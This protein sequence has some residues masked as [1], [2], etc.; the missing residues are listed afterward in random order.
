MK[1][2]KKAKLGLY[3]LGSL[4]LLFVL[5]HTAPV[6]RTVGWGLVRVASYVTS[7]PVS[8]ERL[9]YRL[10]RGEF[11][12]SGVSLGSASQPSPFVLNADRIHLRI[13]PTLR[14][15][16]EVKGLD[17]VLV[18]FFGRPRRENEGSPLPGYLRRLRITDGAVRFKDHN[19]AGDLDEWLV[20]EGI[21]ADALEVEDGHRILFHAERAHGLVG[22]TQVTVDALDADLVLGPGNSRVAS[23]TIFKDDSYVRAEG[24]LDFP[25]GTT[26]VL[27]IRYALDG[28]LAR[29][30]DDELAITGVATGRAQARFDAGSVTIDI[31]LRSEAIGWKGVTV[32]DVEAA[33]TYSGGAVRIERVQARG[34]GGEAEL[35]GELELREAGEQHLEL[36]WSGLDVV[37]AARH[38]G[39]ETLPF[40]ARISGDAQLEWTGWQLDEA[41]GDARIRLEPGADLSGN[42]RAELLQ[43]SLRLVTDGVEFVPWST[44][45]SARTTIGI[46][47]GGIEAEYELRVSDVAKLARDLPIAISGA[48]TATGFVDGTLETPHWTAHLESDALALQGE[49]FTLTADLEGSTDT[50]L[51]HEARL[52]GA[53]G[54]LLAGG[55]VPLDADQSWG[56]TASL[57]GF[58]V[59]ITDLL[60]EATIDGTIELTGRA[61][62]PDWTTQLRL[63]SFS[64]GGREGSA[65]LAADKRD[66]EIRIRELDVTYAGGTLDGRGLYALDSGS[67]DG[68]LRLTGMQLREL[69]LFDKFPYDVEGVVQFEATFAG[70]LQKPE[71]RARLAIGELT[72]N[73]TALPAVAFDLVAEDGNV[74]IEGTREGGE[75]LLSGRLQ[76]AGDYPLHL[77]IPL[78]ALPVTEWMHSIGVLLDRDRA[79]WLMEGAAEV[80]VNLAAP[81]TLAYEAKV[82]SMEARFPNATVRASP[83]EVSGNADRL[84]ISGFEM[85]G[86]RLRLAVNGTI[87]FTRHQAID[88]VAKGNLDLA[89]LGILDPELTTVGQ[90]DFNVTIGGSVSEPRVR[91]ELHVRDGSGSYGDLRWSA[92]NITLVAEDDRLKDVLL[93]AEVLDGTVTLAGELPM[94]SDAPGGFLEVDIRDIDLAGLLPPERRAAELSVVISARGK[95][96]VP[97]LEVESLAGAGEL[98]SLVIKVGNLSVAAVPDTP[99]RVDGGV[100]SVPSLRLEGAGGEL[101]LEHL[102]LDLAGGLDA[103][104]TVKGRLNAEIFNPLLA[105]QGMQ[106][107][108]EATLDVDIAIE[109]GSVSLRGGG[110]IRRG[111]FTSFRP[112][113]S[114]TDAVADFEFSETAIRVTRMEARRGPG[115]LQGSG[116]IDWAN[117]DQ[118]LVDLRVVTQAFPVEIMAGFRSEVSGEL[119]LGNSGGQPLLSGNLSLNRGVLTREFDDDEIALSTQSVALRDPNYLQ[120]VLPELGL[121]LVVTTERNVRIENSTARLEVAGNI[122]VRGTVAVPEAG[123]FLT[124]VPDGTLNIGANRLRTVG[125]RIDLTGFPVVQPYVDV[126]AV[127]RVG[128]T[129]INVAVR[130]YADDL[131]TSLTAPDN[132]ELTEGDLASLLV[133]GRTLEN[134]GEGGVQIAATW[135]M[136]S[137]AGLV[138]EGLADLITFG[139]PLGAGPLILSEEADPTSRLSFGFPVTERLSVT[140]SIALDSTERRL[141]ILDYRVARN[142]W[143]R[144]IQEN[145]SDFGFGISQRF[146]FDLRRRAPSAFA[147]RRRDQ[148][149]GTVVVEGAPP[150]LGRRPRLN[151]GDRYDYWR[152]WDEAARLRDDLVGAGYLSAV[153]DAI[154]AIEKGESAD[155]VSVRYVVTLGIRSAIVWRG[156]DPGRNVRREIESAWDGRIPEE[157]LLADATVALRTRLRAERY[158]VAEVSASTELRE[159]ADGP[160]L[161]IVFDVSKGPRG[162]SVVLSFEGNHVLGDEELRTA[163]PS[164]DTPEFFLLLERPA[165]LQRGI[166]L[167]YAAEGYLDATSG[168]PRTRFDSGSGAFLVEVPV[169]EGSLM[170]IVAVDLGAELSLDRDRIAES[171]GV[172][173]GAPVALPQIRE[174]QTRVRTLYRSEGFNDV[175]VR[176]A[177]TRTEKGLD[178]ELII[179]E[180]TR[181]RVG[182]IRIVGNTRTLPHVIL[183]ELTFRSGDPVRRTAFQSTQKRLYDLAIFRSA[184]VRADR[185]QQGREIQDVVIQVVER[186]DVEVSYGIRYNFISSEQSIS[187]ESEPRSSGFLLNARVNFLNSFRRGTNLGFSAF[188]EGNYHL[189]RGTLRMPTFFRRRIVTEFIL[190]AEKEQFVVGGGVPDLVSRGSSITFQQTRKLTAVRT[191]KFALQWNFRYAR[192]RADRVNDEGD[193]QLVDTYRPRF[194]ISLIEDRRDS[195]A[196]PTRG[197][198]WS[199]TVQAVPRIWGSDVGWVRLYGQAF[200]YYP[201]TRSVVWASGV[202]AGVSSGTQEFLL[203]EDR[204][205]TGGANSVRGY[206]QNTL[207]PVVFINLPEGGGRLYIGGQSVAVINQELRFP[208]WSIL[209]G[210]LFWDAGNVWATTREFS[211]ADLKH[212][213][214]A[215]VRVVLPFGALRFDYAVPLNPCTLEQLATR[216]LSR[217]AADVMKFHFSFGYAF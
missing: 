92:L 68:S 51:L 114:L 66:R 199:V 94:R 54:T 188:Y 106:V 155:T 39:A 29:L 104:G 28:S 31:D 64:A 191:D 166:R 49:P 217:C 25:N 189:F 207:G 115:R 123:G 69:P 120:G 81:E 18:D 215:G 162:E 100:L 182:E 137:L 169:E 89:F 122:S 32:H 146:E 30:I 45:L 24:T 10:W 71:G 201:I 42:L 35:R 22:Q 126:R 47:T 127:A 5:S 172:A 141:F 7:V 78:G 138:H 95:I 110:A 72:H 74:H 34:L 80:D 195:F 90:A 175:T 19:A 142:I 133:T 40:T 161:D 204:F 16:V 190:E 152:V 53:G 187:Q 52:K 97:G 6:R 4:L 130:G 59:G 15:S 192:F 157:F 154:T 125:G 113:F 70:T 176:A 57:E 196:S 183:N 209:R 181:A 139:P 37:E 193:V 164:T 213:I 179:D 158:F 194:G 108:G 143:L 99:W 208:I 177:L 62:D 85:A 214:G 118:P 82:E 84:S 186:S 79:Q 197:R 206:K 58:E 11:E 151:E 61:L 63:R 144:A 205:Q 1:V 91:G 153:V 3:V 96:N 178:V 135:A 36:R 43:G 124:V 116:V 167:R 168:E 180:G 200:F 211:L 93:T 21:S 50:A 159:G 55:T 41:S 173:P 160:L 102:S 149:V 163:L 121:D 76:L 128:N 145:A 147:T 8:L 109:Q 23:A 65:S 117:L 198:F 156:E 88:V 134:A 174:G 203:V 2:G 111:R 13:S 101:D 210:G 67:V 212:S 87:P 56:V 105:A 136:S 216:P 27:D 46:A 38:V 140:Y 185:D 150:G 165:D 98:G 132:P 14:L 170:R 86:E 77:E 26:G 75:T 60:V 148:L 83:F 119:R 9:E 107:G 20:V 112:Q 103:Q 44:T 202:R 17:V 12:L 131:R 33:A 184:D 129:T 73:D 171:F 48:V